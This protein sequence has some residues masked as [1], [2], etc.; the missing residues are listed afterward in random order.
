MTETKNFFEQ[1]L[2]MW[3]KMNTTY[4]DT[5]FKAVEKSMEQSSVLRKQID[6]AVKA[7]IGA[8]M[9]ITLSSIQALERQVEALSKKVDQLQKSEK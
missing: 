8:Q 2:E 4:M 1:N 7:A 3:E 6:E 5:M 9:A